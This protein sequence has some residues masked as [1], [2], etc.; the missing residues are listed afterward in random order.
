M[1]ILMKVQKRLIKNNVNILVM[2]F[3]ITDDDA[4]G[5][6]SDCFG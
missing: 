1:V 2:F 3:M 5:V 4:L 6:M